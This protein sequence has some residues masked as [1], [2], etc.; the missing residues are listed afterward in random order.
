MITNDGGLVRFKH[1][2]VEE[3]CRL[4]WE[5]NLN[6][7]TKNELVYKLIPGPKAT[8]R[9]CI[10][11]ERELVRQRINLSLGKNPTP[12]KKDSKNV[13]WANILCP[14]VYNI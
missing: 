11:K 14:T 13:M 3:V 12:E 7:E 6:E 5:D 4:A 2:V 8:Y 9:C 10:Y 1:D